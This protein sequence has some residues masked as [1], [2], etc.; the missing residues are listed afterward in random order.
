M[1]HIMNDK[2]PIQDIGRRSARFDARDKALGKEMFASDVYPDNMLWAGAYRPGIPH[3]EIHSVDTTRAEAIDG[4]YAILTRK[5][6]KGPNRQGF[7]YW[8]M[9]VLCGSRVRY[10][11]DAVALVLAETRQA[12]SEALQCIEVDITP[13]SVINSIDAALLEDAVQ[14]HQ[15]DSG[16]VLKEATISHGDAGAAM[17]EA[18]VVLE[19]TFFTPIQEHAYIETEN[20]VAHQ[21]E[22]GIIHLTVSTQAPFRDRFE[23][24]K[25]LQLDPSKIHITNPYLGGGFGGKD[26]ATVQCLLALAAMHS[27]GRP[28]KMWW[29]REESILAGYKRHS[30]RLHYK[31]AAKKDGTLLALKCELDYDTGA[32]AHLGVEVMALGLEHAA[33]PYRVKN[34]EATGRCIYTNNPIAGAFRGFGVAQVSFAFEGMMDRLAIELDLDPMQLRINNALVR[35]DKNG[36]G[37]TMTNSTGIEECLMRLQDHALW[38]TKNKWIKD[39]PQFKRRCVGVSAVYNGMGYGRGLADYAI[40][41]IRLTESGTI[42]VY[43]GVSD[44]GQGNASTFGQIAGEILCQRQDTLEIVQLDTDTGHPSGSATAGRTTY[45]YGNALIKACEALRDK[46]F[47]RAALMLMQDN[48]AT[49]AMVPGGVRHLTTGQDVPLATLA[50]MMHPDDRLSMGDYLMPTTPEM[51]KGGEAFKLGFPHLIYPYGAHLVYL[52]IDELTGQ[53]TVCS[54][55]TYTDAGR[56]LNPQNYEQQVQGAIAQGLGYALLEDIQVRDAK[57]LTKDLSTYI[58]PTSL[59]I[60]DIESHAVETI[61]HSGPFG[62]KGIGEVG[63][64]GPLPAIAS[65]LAHTGIPMNCSPF[66]PQRVLAALQEPGSKKLC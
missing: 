64:N 52:E 27:N 9:P 23:I 54:Y 11:G 56:V 33:G 50:A 39:A 36:T 10:E 38:K 58:L 42:K 7:I 3:G 45:T 14:V 32:Y 65:A 24:A 55:V 29:D 40:A 35:G 26:G 28:V 1:I 19:E 49:F 20:G 2:S 16:N 6:I 18:D 57:L 48:T 66:T 34:M 22:N 43:N 21:D 4:V 59:D 12:L 37:V 25:A 62:M 30:A 5:D 53:I 44:M 13:L 46:L 31:L 63:F 60:P 47:N 8:D 17:N 61:E 15:L 41:K 51:P